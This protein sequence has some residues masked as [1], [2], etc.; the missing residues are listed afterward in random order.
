MSLPD[1]PVVL[2]AHAAH[3][4]HDMPGLDSAAFLLVF[5]LA[6]SVAACCVPFV[7]SLMAWGA[8]RAMLDVGDRR[9]GQA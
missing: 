9:D 7:L 5:L 2:A 4:A 3:A 6:L 8:W 1:A